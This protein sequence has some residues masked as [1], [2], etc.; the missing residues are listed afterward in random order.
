MS[1]EALASEI[2]N[3]AIREQFSFI[4]EGTV[5]E[6]RPK[7]VLAGTKPFSFSG[8]PEESGIPADEWDMENDYS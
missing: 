4:T 8:T 2:I 7:P 6:L 3:K 1:I 5:S